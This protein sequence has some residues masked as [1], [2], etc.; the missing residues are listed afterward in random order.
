MRARTESGVVGMEINEVDVVGWEAPVI[1]VVP[2]F[3]F[4][5]FFGAGLTEVLDDYGVVSCS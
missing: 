1:L 5:W 2:C 4:G 3:P